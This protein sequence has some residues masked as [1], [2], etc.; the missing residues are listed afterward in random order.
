MQ[1]R[2]QHP[3]S[4]HGSGNRAPQPPIKYTLVFTLMPAGTQMCMKKNAGL[5]TCVCAH[6]GARTDNAPFGRGYNLSPPFIPLF[7][8][9]PLSTSNRESSPRRI[10]KKTTEGF[11]L[12]T[13]V[14]N[15]CFSHSPTAI[16]IISWLLYIIYDRAVDRKR[17]PL[18]QG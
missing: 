5:H 12:L 10:K 2:A 3:S 11:H 18:H 15:C 9:P 6:N 16:N 4:A 1:Q 17:L 13:S 14:A 8:W 7:S